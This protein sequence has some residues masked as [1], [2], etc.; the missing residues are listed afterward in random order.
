MSKKDNFEKS[1]E[2]NVTN[3][4][5]DCC[6]SQHSIFFVI[7]ESTQRAR[8]VHNTRMERLVSYKHSNL[9]IQLISYEKKKCCECNT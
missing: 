5:F 9:L 3:C 8:V 2:G 1:I 6:D 7:I 4:Q